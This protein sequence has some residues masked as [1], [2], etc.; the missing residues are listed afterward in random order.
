MTTATAMTTG[1]P[2]YANSRVTAFYA[3]APKRVTRSGPAFEWVVCVRSGDVVDR[4]RFEDRFDAETFA[5]TVDPD[6]IFP[7]VEGPR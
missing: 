1:D 4:H 2:R 5:L 7:D 6:F 3:D